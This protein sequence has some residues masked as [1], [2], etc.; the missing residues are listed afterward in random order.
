MQSLVN[1]IVLLSAVTVMGLVKARTA[2]EIAFQEELGALFLQPT[3][4]APNEQKAD[5]PEFMKN[6]YS[7]MSSN[8]GN[9][10]ALYQHKEVN[11]IRSFFGTG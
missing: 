4:S 3:H 9:C 8:H 7:C 6:A 1:A 5:L 2:D 10:P 11:L